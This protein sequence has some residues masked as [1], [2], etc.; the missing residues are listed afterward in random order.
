MHSGE[1]LR[2]RAHELRI[3]PIDLANQLDESTQNINAWFKRGVPHAKVERVASAIKCSAMWLRE[4]EAAAQGVADDGGV[5]YTASRT[6]GIALVGTAALDSNGQWSAISKDDATGRAQALPTGDACY[7]LRIKGDSLA[8]AI[9]NGWVVIVEPDGVP[10]P[11]EYVIICTSDN[12][13]TIKEFLY[14]RGQEYTLN[15]LGNE[16]KTI[17]I[18]EMATDRIEPIAAIIP[19]SKVCY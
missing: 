4:G 14:K 19:P 12:K 9:P 15:N 7:A 1:R 8:P 5:G 11:G 16:Y 10:H 2:K 17:V 13:C 6:A 3:R 18:D